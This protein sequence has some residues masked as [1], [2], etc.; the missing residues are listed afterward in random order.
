MSERFKSGIK[1]RLK[2]GEEVI[3]VAMQV[4]NEN[5]PDKRGSYI[6]VVLED[7]NCLTVR[8][9]DGTELRTIYSS[10]VLS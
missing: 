2:D 10:E 9:A 8:S 4:R 7:I 3:L 6:R 5:D 1:L